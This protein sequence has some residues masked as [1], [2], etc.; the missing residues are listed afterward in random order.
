[1]QSSGQLGDETRPVTQLVKCVD[2]LAFIVQ[3][4]FA[5]ISQLKR[6]MKSQTPKISRK[7]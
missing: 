7:R 2:E 5:E 3:G 4:Q 6:Q 1:M